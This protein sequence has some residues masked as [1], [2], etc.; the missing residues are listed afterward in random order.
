MHATVVTSIRCV[1]LH[2]VEGM[3]ESPLPDPATLS[4]CLHGGTTFS[5]GLE[6]ISQRDVALPSKTCGRVLTHHQ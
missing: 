1:M 3:A 5:T 2:A 4:A 6:V